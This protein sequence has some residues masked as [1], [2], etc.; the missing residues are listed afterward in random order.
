MWLFCYTRKYSWDS[1]TFEICVIFF[2]ARSQKLTIYVTCCAVYVSKIQT[3]LMRIIVVFWTRKSLA[4]AGR[5]EIRSP[6]SSPNMT[7]LLI[8][9]LW[10][11]F[12]NYSGL[13]VK[14]HCW[15]SLALPQDNSY[16]DDSFHATYL[17]RFSQPDKWLFATSVSISL[18]GIPLKPLWVPI[19]L[20]NRGL[21][22]RGCTHISFKKLSGAMQNTP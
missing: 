21:M 16:Y 19:A 17:P 12:I 14:Q 2:G 6:P 13:L 1:S 7:I 3:T 8:K 22:T 5:P 18:T 4:I 9:N 20:L 15:P 11:D 10:T